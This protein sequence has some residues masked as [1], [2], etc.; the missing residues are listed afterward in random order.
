MINKII[1]ISNTRLDYSLNS[2]CIKGLSENGV[3]VVGFYVKGGGIRGLIKT[4]SFYLHNS[5]DIDAV[6]IGYDSPVLVALFRP[7]CRKKIIY[8]AALSVYERMIISR[9]LASRFSV[10]AVYYWFIDFVA[11]HLANLVIVETDHQADFFKKIFKISGKKIYKSWIGV[12]E[13]KFFYNPALPKYDSFTVLFR[14]AFMPESGVEYAIKAAK[15]LEDKNIKF[16]VIGS[17]ILLKKVKKLAEELKPANLELITDYVSYDTL[18]TTMQRCH[19]SLG[20]L[21]NHDRL[22]RTIPHKAYESLAMKLPYLTASNIGVL[23]L[24]AP[25]E[26]CLACSPADA[27]SLAEKILWAKN[28]YPV[29]EKIAENGYKQYQDQLKSSILAGNILNKIS[30]I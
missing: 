14:G 2:A 11:V 26:T 5:G 13:N 30:G 17:G 20:Q 4:V 21:S 16:I 25:G 9:E 12:D 23:E 28:N 19:L 7:F 24:L 1:Y 8:N 6:M 3:E 18:R 22:S 29:A 27:N 15:I 10:K